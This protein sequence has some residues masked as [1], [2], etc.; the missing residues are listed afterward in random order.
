MS[1]VRI[2]AEVNGRKVARETEA[3]MRLLDFLREDL[4]LTGTKEGCGA[5]ECG[6][7]SGSRHPD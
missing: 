6:T 1:K 5:G 4:N 7:C 3:H 2:E